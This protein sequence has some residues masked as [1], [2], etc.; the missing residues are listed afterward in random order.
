MTDE[1]DKKYLVCCSGWLAGLLLDFNS[2]STD[3]Q[4][5][6]SLFIISWAV[7]SNICVV[8]GVVVQGLCWGCYLGSTLARY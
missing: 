7:I 1:A 4:F 5:T 3:F 6:G 8:G 2:L